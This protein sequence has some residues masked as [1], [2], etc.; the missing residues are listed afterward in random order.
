MLKLKL[1]LFSIFVLIFLFCAT[2]RPPSGGPVDKTPPEVVAVYP[3]PNATGVELDTDIGIEFSERIEKKS[4][5]GA[6]FISP[7]QGE[8]VEYHWKGKKLVVDFPDSLKPERTYVL[9]I[10]TDVIDLRRNRMEQAFHLAFSTGDKLD[11][12]RISG[13][14]HSETG[15]EG[16]IVCLYEYT[17]SLQPDPSKNFPEYMTQCNKTGE[18]QFSYIAPGKY[19]PLALKDK[20]YNQKYDR[21]FDGV[22]IPTTIAELSADQLSISGINFR[23]TTEDTT[24]VTLRGV[25]SSDRHHID[26]KFDGPIK[27]PNFTAVQR[28]FV[29]VNEKTVTDTLSIKRIYQ[30]TQDLSR[31][32]LKTAAM[33][34]GSYVLYCSDLFDM[35]GNPLDSASQFYT[36]SGSSEPDTVK[37]SLI[38][39]SIQQNAKNVALQPAINLLFSEAMD[40]LS[41]EQHFRLADSG[42]VRQSGD[43][44]WCNPADVTFT[45]QQ[46]LE[47]NMPYITRLPVDSVFDEFANPLADSIIEIRFTT[48]NL[49]TLSS[50]SGVIVDKKEHGTGQFYLTAHNTTSKNIHYETT[51]DSAGPY[52]FRGIFPGIYL[53]NGFR[54]ED[55][56]GSYSHGQ[57]FPFKPAE[58]FLFYPD[59]VKIRSRWPNEGNDLIFNKY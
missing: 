26:I 25:L 3:A 10:G 12:G 6:I 36:F 32:H 16:T 28:Y 8:N 55:N 33:D 41:F 18:Y 43:F 42:N 54:D 31:F 24:Q 44:H 20:D 40:T 5:S 50:L 29:I 49:D 2:Q 4:I 30:N 56:N 13:T 14:V 7:R 58:R 53:I 21:G 47:S 11:Q 1:L 45:P 51:V 15:I 19:L 17:D 22:G 57:V 46:Q 34:T 23:M 27:P 35:A 37:P 38:Q 48:L 59:S 9:T 52:L 39:Q